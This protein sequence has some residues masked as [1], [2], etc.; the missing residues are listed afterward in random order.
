MCCWSREARV[1]IAL[2]WKGFDI[3][4]IRTHDG[5]LQA[6]GEEK[7]PNGRAIRLVIIARACC[8]LPDDLRHF[9][10]KWKRNEISFCTD[11]FYLTCVL[12]QSFHFTSS[13]SRQRGNTFHSLHVSHR[14]DAIR[15]FSPILGLDLDVGLCFRARPLALIHL[16]SASQTR[17]CTITLRDNNG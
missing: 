2:G 4:V 1:W 9:F 5:H 13:P 14:L 17:S 11:H 15:C 12:H 10:S 3:C 16:P 6:V 7:A 8:L